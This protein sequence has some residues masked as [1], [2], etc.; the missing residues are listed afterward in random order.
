[1]R[2]AIGTIVVDVTRIRL[3]GAVRARHRGDSVIGR[4]RGQSRGDARRV[5]ER[6][7]PCLGCGGGGDGARRR[8]DPGRI[9]LGRDVL[10]V[11]ARVVLDRSRFSARAG[12]GLDRHGRLG[13]HLARGG[14]ND[15]LGDR[16]SLGGREAGG[17]EIFDIMKTRHRPRDMLEGASWVTQGPSSSRPL[18]LARLRSGGGTTKL[19][20]TRAPRSA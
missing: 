20:R 19:A 11:R 9:R 6:E 1:M 3:G 7:H 5:D 4:E 8:L 13:H 18:G 12:P 17:G 14:A 16:V 15:Q 2:R 10:V